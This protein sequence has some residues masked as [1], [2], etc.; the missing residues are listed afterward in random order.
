[1]MEVQLRKD[2][3]VHVAKIKEISYF[4]NIAYVQHARDD[5]KMCKGF[6]AKPEQI[7]RTW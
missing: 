3:V 7:I 4:R 5:D 1:M 2:V 6:L